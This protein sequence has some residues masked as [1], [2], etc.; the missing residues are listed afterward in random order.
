ML[1]ISSALLLGLLV[2]MGVLQL[3][4]PGKPKPFP[5]RAGKPLVGSISEK[6]FV[7]I[8]ATRQ[9]MFIKST[10]AT[11]PVL[12]YLHGGMPDYLLRT[13]MIATSSA[14]MGVHFRYVWAVHIT[15]INLDRHCRNVFKSPYLEGFNREWRGENIEIGLAVGELVY[16]CGVDKGWRCLSTST[17]RCRRPGRSTLYG[18]VPEPGGGSHVSGPASPGDS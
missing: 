14:P 13:S 5:D 4:S 12:L 2:L 1:T 10:D 7:A 17:W 9:G 8:N 18:L 16:F 3:M 11:H 6:L 15:G